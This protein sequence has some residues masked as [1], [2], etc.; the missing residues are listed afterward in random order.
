[1]QKPSKYQQK[2]LEWLTYGNG[3]GVCNAVAGAGKTTTLKLAAQKLQALGFKPKDIKVI[4][5][6]KQ[7]SLDL[8][9]KFGRGW[10]SSIQT[11]HSVGFKILQQEIGRFQ[12]NEKIVS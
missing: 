10:K 8:I 7:N 6:G 12:R 1:M 11:L 3:N 5:F 9:E 2:I 4:V